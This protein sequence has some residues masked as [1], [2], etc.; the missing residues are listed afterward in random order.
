MYKYAIFR[1]A[2][3]EISK[4]GMLYT[5][6]YFATATHLQCGVQLY[7][8]SIFRGSISM[9]AVQWSDE[10]SEGILLIVIHVVQ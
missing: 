4:R 1:T 7:L 6:F 10:I 9:Q 3:N 8:A 5:K 2:L